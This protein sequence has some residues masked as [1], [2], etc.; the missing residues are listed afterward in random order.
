[1]N[2]ELPPI[3]EGMKAVRAAA[4]NL[5]E[6]AWKYRISYI[7]AFGETIMTGRTD[8]GNEVGDLH[9]CTTAITPTMTEAASLFGDA[10]EQLIEQGQAIGRDFPG[11]G[12]DEIYDECVKLTRKAWEAEWEE[13]DRTAS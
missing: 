9:I 3:S 1:M 5:I 6:L 8:D 12:R 4:S 2:E 7:L 13:E 10:R 11:L